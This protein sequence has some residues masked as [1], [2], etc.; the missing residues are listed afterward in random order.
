MTSTIKRWLYL[1]MTHN[2]R[3]TGLLN[4]EFSKKYVTRTHGRRGRICDRN[5][6]VRRVYGSTRALDLNLRPPAGDLL[7]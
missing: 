6:G 1:S 3:F 5:Y 2:P 7:L 4:R